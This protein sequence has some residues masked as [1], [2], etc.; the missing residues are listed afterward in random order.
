VNG[1][2]KKLVQERGFGFIKPNDGTK[3]VFMH[4]KALKNI[5]F[6]DLNEGDSVTFDVQQG[7]K[8]PQ[9]ANVCV[10]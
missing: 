6:E 3:D 5:R 1:T 4:A 10:P 2:V 8:G 7:D 9:A